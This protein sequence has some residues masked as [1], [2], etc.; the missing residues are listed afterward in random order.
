MLDE[1]STACPKAGVTTAAASNAKA[2]IGHRKSIA[3]SW[4]LLLFAHRAHCCARTIMA[5]PPSPAMN[6]A[7]SL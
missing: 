1:E 5:A 4:Y 2:K 6:P 7:A 3:P